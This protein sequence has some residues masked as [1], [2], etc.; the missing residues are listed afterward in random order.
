MFARPLFTNPG[1]VC[2]GRNIISCSGDIIDKEQSALHTQHN[3]LH[4]EKIMVKMLTRF[5]F[6]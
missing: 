6:K 4:D 5:S 2:A 1:S 3:D